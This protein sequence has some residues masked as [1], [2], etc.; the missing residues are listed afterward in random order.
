MEPAIFL[1]VTFAG[2]LLALVLRLPPLVGFLAAGFTLNFLGVAEI[3]ALGVIADLGVTLL[4]FGIGLKL[5]V[6]S[7]VRKEVWGTAGLHLIASLV[8]GVAALAGLTALGLIGQTGWSQLALLALAMSFSS[9][10]LVVKFLESRG[11]VEAFYGRVAIGILVMQDIVAVVFITASKGTLPS[12][13]AF[14]LILLL[15][16]AWVFRKIWDRLGHGEMQALF[17]VLMALVPGYALFELVGLKG[18]LGALIMGMLLATH[19][20]AGELSRTLLTFKE[21]LLVGFFVSIGMVGLPTTQS[22]VVALILVLVAV[23]AKALGYLLL[24][25][26]FGLRYRTAT[27]VALSLSSFS[28]FAL[29]VAVVEV[30]AGLLDEEWVVTLSLAV[31]MSFVLTALMNGRSTNFISHVVRRFPEQNHSRLHPED[32]LIEIGEASVVILGMGRIGQSTYHHLTRDYELSV[33]GVEHDGTRVEKLRAKGMQILEEDATDIAFWERL[34][35][36]GTAEIAVLAMPLHGANLD[37]LEQL[38]E[39]EFTGT[40]AAVARYQ[41]EATE[42]EKLGVD[43]VFQLYDGAGFAIADRIMGIGGSVTPPRFD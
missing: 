24:L 42:L 39:S 29:I 33:L 37:A 13:W 8:A 16:A 17:G 19:P 23:P 4:L 7:L 28:E 26:M 21:L 6:R 41:D 36:S 2:G 35:D 14:A 15:P 12:P 38:R 1:A 43:V 20:A 18:D 31:A 25:W 30:K 11:D 3:P 5:D 9:T 27:L 32:R 40:V 34:I 10:V 22:F